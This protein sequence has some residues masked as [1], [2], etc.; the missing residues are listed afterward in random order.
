V[1]YTQC[2]AAVTCID[3][4]ATIDL[5]RLASALGAPASAL[6]NVALPGH[7]HL[8]TTR[9]GDQPE[10]WNV[11]VIPVATPAGL[12][13]VESSKSYAAVKALEGAS[14]SGIGAEVDTNAYLW[15]QTLPGAGP[16]TPGQSDAAL[17]LGGGSGD[18]RRRHR[19]LRGRLG[20]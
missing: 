17:G 11:I 18:R 9:N 12:A 14:G 6:T 5:S 1:A 15:F 7:D 16:A 13:S 10:W 3:H 2:S 19:L 8:L 4:P 20:R